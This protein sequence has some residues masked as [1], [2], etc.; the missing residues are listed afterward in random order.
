MVSQKLSEFLSA[1]GGYVFYVF[2]LR[3]MH[4]MLF[5]VQQGSPSARV[6]RTV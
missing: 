3:F 2:D 5:F 6:P 1:L 4:E